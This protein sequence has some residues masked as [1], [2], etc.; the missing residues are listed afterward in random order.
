MWVRKAIGA[1]GDGKS[2]QIGPLQAPG[3]HGIKIPPRGVVSI[4]KDKG[5]EAPCTLPAHSRCFVTGSPL[6]PLQQSWGPR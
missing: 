6:C 5:C 1:A 2:N 4:E 3:G